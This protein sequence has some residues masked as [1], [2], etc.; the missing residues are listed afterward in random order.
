[1]SDFKIFIKTGKCSSCSKS[2]VIQRKYNNE[3]LCPE[4]FT[5]DIENKIYSTIKEYNLINPSDKIIVGLSGGKDSITLLYNLK[6][7]QEKSQYSNEIIALI[8]DEGISNYRNKSIASAKKFCKENEIDYK[9]ISF[10]ERIGKTLEDIIIQKKNS[11]DY[12]YACN[13]CAIFR[14]RLLNDGAKELK[15]D[16]LAVGHNLTDIAETFLMNILFKRFSLIA[17]KNIFE[18]NSSKDTNTYYIKKIKPL[19]KI[20]EEEIFLYVNIKN[21]TYYPSHCPYSKQD[22]IMRRKVLNFIQNSKNS[23]PDVELNLLNGYNALSHLLKK[24]Y[25]IE[26]KNYC[27]NCGYPCNKIICQYCSYKSV[28][29]S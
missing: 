11:N 27:Q 12:E 26:R 24:Y 4:C 8:I 25:K 6:K 7:I 17:Q 2:L 18:V 20:P 9:I 19:M 29:K 23:I 3:D 21:L 22:P 10:K 5:I 13:Y 28:I 1:M 16:I 14:R 15:G